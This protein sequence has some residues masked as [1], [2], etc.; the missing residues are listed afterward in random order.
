MWTSPSRAVG[1]LVQNRPRHGVLLLAA[2]AGVTGTFLWGFTL[3]LAF[4]G[5]WSLV[6]TAN[7]VGRVQGISAWKGLAN[8]G[9][10]G[11]VL[12]V[13]LAALSTMV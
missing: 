11:A 6:L 13:S 2:L 10:A 5:V 9:L 3:V 12:L 7:A 1:H 4:L 8:L